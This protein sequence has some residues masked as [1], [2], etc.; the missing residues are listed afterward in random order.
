MPLLLLLD[1]LTARWTG[2]ELV[3]HPGH[4]QW[5]S[6]KSPGRDS[7]LMDAVPSVP[8]CVVTEHEHSSFHA[9][10]CGA[11]LTADFQEMM[12][13]GA[14]AQA[15][16]SVVTPKPFQY[17]APH[18]GSDARVA[19]TRRGSSHDGGTPPAF[20]HRSRGDTQTS[21]VVPHSPLTSKR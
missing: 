3:L 4:I 10:P 15:R 9:Y 2:A 7:V 12:P 21:S 17:S 13:A 1:K 19:S 16:H 6:W 8:E 18:A 14:F 20:A 11:T 5:L